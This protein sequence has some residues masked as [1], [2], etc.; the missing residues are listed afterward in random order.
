MSEEAERRRWKE[1]GGVRCPHCDFQAKNDGGLKVHMGHKHAEARWGVSSSS[2]DESG[3]SSMA[4]AMSL[5]PSRFVCGV[6]QQDC[7]S[8]A[9]LSS[10]MRWRHQGQRDQGKK[11]KE[12]N[13]EEDP[14]GKG[15]KKKK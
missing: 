2:E 13:E 3:P 14:K 9:G 6:C 12:R 11:K 8:G 5:G 10:H 1:G 15:K 4:V 7:G